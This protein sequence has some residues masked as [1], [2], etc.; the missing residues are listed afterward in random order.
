MVIWA[1][2]LSQAQ[3]RKLQHE[4]LNTILSVPAY[5]S[6]YR[7]AIILLFYLDY[8]TMIKFK[9]EKT[10]YGVNCFAYKNNEWLYFGHF[11]SRNDAMRAYDAYQCGY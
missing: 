11:N 3:L 7:R 4:N 1:R 10:L 8:E 9:Y 2:G 5:C 6:H